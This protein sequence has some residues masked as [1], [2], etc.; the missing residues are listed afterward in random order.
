VKVFI[1]CGGLGTRL[2]Q[3]TEFRPKPMV[4]I[5][6]RPILWHIMKI[7]ASHG[8]TD[9]VL[10]LGYKANMIKDYFLNYEA[11]GSDLT[12]ELGRANTVRY[13]GAGHSESGWKVTLAF[14]GEQAGTGARI[15]RAA[16]Y[17][18][19][20]PETFAAT[21]GDGVSDVNL[22]KALEFHRSQRKLA[23]VTGV[24]PP[25]RFGDIQSEGGRVTSF[26]EKAQSGQGMINGGFFFFEPGFLKY[27]GDDE[28]CALEG[29]PLDTCVRDGQ[30]G[31]YEHAG[32]WQ[33]MD[34]FRELEML[35]RQWTSGNAPWKTW[36]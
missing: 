3:E 7:Y 31:V 10:C 15:K 20:E 9:F 17:L 30:L 29:Q 4:E 23:T 24:R 28:D 16:R 34:T 2:R 25:S 33:C 32:Y 22:R 18:G 35:E 8:M 27:I 6:G 19:P 21:Y 5:G 12:V 11:M 36:K 1:L 14:T 26:N 13:H